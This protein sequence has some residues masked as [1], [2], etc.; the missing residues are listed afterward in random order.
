MYCLDTNTISFVLLNRYKVSETLLQVNI[1]ELSTTIISETE[2]LYGAYNSSKIEFNLT[3]I[4]G[5]LGHLKIYGID[6]QVAEIFA[7]EKTRLQKLGKVI[8]NMDLLIACICIK[9]NLILV[10]DNEKHFKQIKN[11]KIENW[12]KR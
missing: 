11:L 10:T 8:E 1:S 6:S 4:K 7:K 3:Q 12:A 2:L 9:E 5:F